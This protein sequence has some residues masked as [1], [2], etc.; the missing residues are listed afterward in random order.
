LGLSVVQK[1]EILKSLKTLTVKVEAYYMYLK[2]K[3]LMFS[4][5]LTGT[6]FTGHPTATTFG[7]TW[8]MYFYT[9][10][11]AHKA[12]IKMCSGHA[13]D[14][15]VAIISSKDYP[16]LYASIIK[17]SRVSDVK[18]PE[19]YGLGQNLREFKRSK[20]EFDFLSR[21]GKFILG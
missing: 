9:R 19:S 17:Y 20:T 8:R 14:D 6:T 18:D 11:F 15:V 12:N 7:N 4:A 10:F 5:D 21:D 16:A 1:N 3:N 13:G 2:G